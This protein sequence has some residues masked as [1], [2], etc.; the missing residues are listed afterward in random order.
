MSV[1]YLKMLIIP[2]C[3]FFLSLLFVRLPFLVLDCRCW[4]NKMVKGVGAEQ[5]PVALGGRRKEVHEQEA[6]VSCA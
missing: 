1:S 2:K 3:G 6:Q 4:Q 5:T